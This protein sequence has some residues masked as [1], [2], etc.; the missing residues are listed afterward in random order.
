M[1]DLSQSYVFDAP[2]RALSSVQFER[3]ERAD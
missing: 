3:R 2:E 1:E